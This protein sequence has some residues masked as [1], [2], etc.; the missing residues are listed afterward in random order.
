M[1]EHKQRHDTAP[2]PVDAVTKEVGDAGTVANCSNYAESWRELGK[3]EGW[4]GCS[5]PKGHEGDCSDAS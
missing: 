4:P 3:L 2:D 1:T 5:K